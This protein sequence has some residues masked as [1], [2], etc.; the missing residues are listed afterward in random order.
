MSEE[1]DRQLIE[2]NVGDK[3]DDDVKET[4]GVLAKRVRNG[5]VYKHMREIYAFI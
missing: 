2:V 4:D 3:K 1:P 5:W